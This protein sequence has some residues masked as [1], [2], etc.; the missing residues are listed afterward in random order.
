MHVQKYLIGGFFLG[1]LLLAAQGGGEAVSY[2]AP[3]FQARGH[4]RTD[5]YTYKPEDR[6]VGNSYTIF[7]KAWGPGW[8]DGGLTGEPPS[9]ARSPTFKEIFN[10]PSEIPIGQG[11][12]SLLII[13][14][15]SPTKVSR[16]PEVRVLDVSHG[17]LVLAHTRALLESQGMEFKAA[18]ARLPFSSEYIYEAYGRKITIRT[19]D[20]S[21]FKDD[22][23]NGL[24]RLE[25]I[26]NNVNTF[27]ANPGEMR[28][29]DYK[30]NES[31][32]I[33]MSFSLVPCAAAL[34][35]KNYKDNINN[36]NNGEKYI[37]RFLKELRSANPF[38]SSWSDEKV[39]ESILAVDPANEF[40]KRLKNSI[41]QLRQE[42]PA[43]A[44]AASGNYGMDTDTYP[45]HMPE[46]ISVGAVSWGT[47][48]SPLT[49]A[50]KKN[51]RMYWSDR[52]DVYSVGGW[53][54]FSQD[55]LD[56]FCKPA[57][58]QNCVLGG[59]IMPAELGYQG[60]SFAA[61]SVAAY[62]ALRATPHTPCY[63]QDTLTGFKF[64]KTDTAAPVELKANPNWHEVI[65]KHERELL[66]SGTVKP[67]G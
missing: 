20:V 39:L 14:Y 51:V 49:V 45:A 29:H 67:C 52:A 64:K 16:G 23:Q 56:Y 60:T 30:E 33:N 66:L 37:E 36:I 4:E 5:S 65:F 35:F 21:H 61:P 25:S 42:R 46:V 55:K 53:F 62:F 40:I 47:L 6:C 2:Q 50:K 12:V 43:I 22:S 27:I 19:F 7:G 34:A 17:D 58:G 3:L 13:D 11:E 1:G 54:K 15:F 57:Q 9:E 31:V 63:P 44:V 10:F 41:I 38:M 48:K 24:V 26:M 28:L 32:V 59:D 8:V 18:H